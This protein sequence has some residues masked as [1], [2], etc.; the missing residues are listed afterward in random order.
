MMRLSGWKRALKRA[1]DN[2][3]SYEGNSDHPKCPE[4]G[5]IMDFYGHDDSGDFPYG[6]GYWE[7]DNCGFKIS[8]NEL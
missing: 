3:W 4:C 2:P 8:E 5:N 6:E 7:C 1:V